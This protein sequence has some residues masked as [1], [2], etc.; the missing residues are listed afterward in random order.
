MIFRIRLV[1][2]AVYG[3]V[4][5]ALE[6][7][8]VCIVIIGVAAWRYGSAVIVERYPDPSFEAA[9]LLYLFRTLFLWSQSCARFIR[10]TGLACDALLCVVVAAGFCGLRFFGIPTTDLVLADGFRCLPVCGWFFNGG[11]AFS[12]FG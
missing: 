4:F 7:A 9:G 11:R 6:F 1:W 8:V 5:G 10:F 2:A 12:P 3:I